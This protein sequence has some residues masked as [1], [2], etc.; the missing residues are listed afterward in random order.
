MLYLAAYKLQNNK[1][2]N[3]ESLNSTA[4][5]GLPR[6]ILCGSQ[7]VEISLA[8]ALC[9]KSCADVGNAIASHVTWP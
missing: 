6:D 3:T 7:L 5:V 4:A 1:K 8:T 2:H 9:S